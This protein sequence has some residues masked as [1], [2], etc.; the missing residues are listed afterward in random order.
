ME[1]KLDSSPGELTVINAWA[2]VDPID[3]A[4]AV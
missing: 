3:F 4:V 1:A 2:C